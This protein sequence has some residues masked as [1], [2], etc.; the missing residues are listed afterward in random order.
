MSTNSKILFLACFHC[1]LL[2]LFAFLFLFSVNQAFVSESHHELFVAV[3]TPENYP[4]VWN[5]LQDAEAAWDTPAFIGLAG[6]LLNLLILVWILVKKDKWC[7]VSL[8]TETK[9]MVP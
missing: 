1:I 3:V 8:T 4:K 2:V 7:K 5:V 9:K 6:F